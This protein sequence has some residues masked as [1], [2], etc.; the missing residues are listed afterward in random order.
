MPVLIRMAGRNLFE[1][2]SKSLII[3]ILIAGGVFLRVAGNSLMDT[4]TSGIEKT[5]IANF[6]GDIMI[7]GKAEGD[8]SLFGVQSPGGIETTPVIPYYNRIYE[9]A[10]N[11]PGVRHLTSQVTGFA[12]VKVEEKLE[13][14]SQ[15]ITLLFGIEPDSYR[16]MFDNLVITGGSFLLPGQTGILLS[17]KTLETI[18]EEM[19]T[20]LGVGDPIL[21][22]AFGS[23]GFKIREVPITGVFSLKQSSPA[24][25]M[26]S[27]VDIQTLRALK[28]MT[29]GGET[30]ISLAEE[31]TELLSVEDADLLFG[32]SLLPSEGSGCSG[33]L[34]EADLFSILDSPGDET[35]SE[36]PQIQIDSGAWEYIL[37]RLDSP[38]QVKRFIADF[39]LYCAREGIP[40]AAG[41]WKEAAGPFSTSADVVRIVFN[42]AVL[43]VAI[44]AVIIIMNTL[45]ISVIE[46]T[47]EI[48]T[49][50]ALGAQRGFIRRL[51][52][53]EI[54]TI[55]IVFGLIGIGA[56]LLG[57]GI[58]SLIGIK[59]GNEFVE[60][61]FAGPVLKP[62]IK[63]G[64]VLVIW[65]IVMLI[66]VVANLYPMRLALKVAPIKAIQTE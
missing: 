47:S 40:A 37:L 45:V 20:N 38:R 54:L 62:V 61:L 3:G 50:R 44:V 1:H 16:A 7:T 46:R 19:E 8:I 11:H 41:G 28:G 66:G 33:T 4:A 31:E 15:V 52:N 58:V 27:Y 5:F 51:F 17:E 22:N 6:T 18:N 36:A 57:L 56:A 26:I 55:T 49:M 35:G 9:F 53:L 10:R 65:L 64:S 2:K 34:S 32:G 48:G 39:S 23:T 21:L 12:V 63:A 24:A 59:A 14:E 13:A 42:A 25:D 60:I 43:L 30:E 29:V